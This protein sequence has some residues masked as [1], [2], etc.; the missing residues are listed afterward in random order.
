MEE[1][2]TGEMAETGKLPEE[3]AQNPKHKGGRRR[4]KR[5]FLIAFLLIVVATLAV[6]AYLYYRGVVYYRTHFFPNTKINGMDCG[7]MEAAP[8]VEALE[9]RIDGYALAVLGRDYETGESDVVLGIIAP[10]DIQ[11]QYVG[12]REAVESLLQQQDEFFWMEAYLDRQYDYTLEQDMNF[13]EDMLGSLVKSWEACKRK[14][15]QM[16]QNAYISE[17]SE[18]TGGYEVVPETVGT[19]FDVQKA[20]PRIVEAVSAQEAAINLE[21]QG[22]YREAAVKSDDKRLNR[23]VDDANKWL[24]TKIVYDWNGTEVV[25]DREILKDWVSIEDEKAVLDEE[26]VDAFVKEQAGAYDTYGRRKNFMTT[27]GYEISLPGRNYG[28]KTDV[29]GETE[30]LIALIYQGSTI[31]KEPLYSIRA[32]G[33]QR[34]RELLSGGGSEQPASVPVSGRESGAGD[35]LRIR[36]DDF[37]FRLCDAGRDIRYAVQV[38]GR[39]AG[40]RDIPHAGEILDALLWELWSTRCQL[41]GRFRRRYLCDRRLPWMHQSAPQHGGADLPVCVGGLPGDMLL[42]PGDSVHRP[43]CGAG[44]GGR[45]TGGRAESGGGSGRLG[46]YDSRKEARKYGEK[47]FRKTNGKTGIEM[48]EEAGALPQ[49]GTADSGDGL[50]HTGVPQLQQDEGVCPARG[51][52]RERPCAERGQVQH[53]PQRIS[54]YPLQQK[55]AD[56]R[57]AAP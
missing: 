31:E 39:G 4:R 9:S 47:N 25:V 8:I 56:Q 12:T 46:K 2:Q 3:N 26:A 17:Y 21:E 18:E 27:Y 36:Y 11:L 37:G 13:D 23:T 48:A 15:M 6:A 50:R 54:A 38:H 22:F 16:P 51:C 19:S 57:S 41:E 1:R 55:G 32:E 33:Q 35:G 40:R 53:R 10:E 24:G 7:D 28:W 44:A 20:I 43:A 45:R 14:N 52:D 30:E 34:Y 5:F 29:A 42:S 49:G